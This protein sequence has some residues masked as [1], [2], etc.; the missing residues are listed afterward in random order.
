M[1]ALEMDETRRRN[2]VIWFKPGYFRAD[3]LTYPHP[4]NVAGFTRI[5]QEMNYRHGT[6][7]LS[8]VV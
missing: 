6:D 7:P 1:Q 8:V 3:K 5:S 2:T 4:A